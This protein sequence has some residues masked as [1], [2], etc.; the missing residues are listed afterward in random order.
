[1]SPLRQPQDDNSGVIVP[2]GRGATLLWRGVEEE[3]SPEGGSDD[4]PE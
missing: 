1:M 4:D 3:R 2:G